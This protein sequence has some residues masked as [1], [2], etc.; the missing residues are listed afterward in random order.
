MGTWGTGIFSDDNAA[1][2]RDD[3]RDFIGDGLSSPEATD[4]LLAEWGSSLSREPEYAATFWLALAVTQWKCGRLE[5]RVKARALV[6]CPINKFT[7]ALNLAENRIGSGGPDK[8]AL[9]FIVVG[10]I[11]LDLFHQLSDVAKR[12]AANR[13]LGNQSEPALDLVEPT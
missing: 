4:R 9:V 8:G 1:D 10:D 7:D 6:L 3:Y 12:A 13:L 5:D 2:L 11:L